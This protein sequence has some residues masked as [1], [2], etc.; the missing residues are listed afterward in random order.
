MAIRLKGL[1]SRIRPWRKQLG[2][3]G[4]GNRRGMNGGQ[5]WEQYIAALL[6]G[7]PVQ[8][9]LTHTAV[10]TRG[11][12]TPS[13]TRATTETGQRW[14]ESGYLDFTALAGEMV[15]KGA[16]REYNQWTTSSV[17]LASGAN[18]SLAL[19]AG[20][21]Q[22][23]MGA[24]TGTATFSGTGGATG[25]LGASASGR[26]SVAKT[27]TAGTF[28]VTASVADLADLQVC[29]ITGETD[30]TTIRPYV[31]VGVGDIEV[32]LTNPN[33]D[34]DTAWTKEAG[35]TISGGT[36]NFNG[37]SP[38]NIYTVNG[39]VGI[40]VEITYTISNYVSGVVRI[41]SGNAFGTV[42][43]ANG[44]YTEIIATTASTIFGLEAAA[45]SV[46]TQLSIE[47][48]SGR[49]L[50]HGS[51]VDGVKCY[52]TDRSGN[53]IATTGNYPLVGYVPWE[54]RT[55]SLLHARDLSNAAWVKV[56]CTGVKDAVGSDGVTNSASTL[57]A[58]GSNAT[59]LQTLVLA[60]AAR[61]Y[62]VKLKRK[63]GAGTV[64][65]C[66]D[67]VTFTDIT[68]QI[69]SSTYTTVKIENTSVLN[70]ICGIKLTTSGDAVYVDWNQ[71]EAGAF[72][73]PAIDT[74]TVAVARNANLLTYTGADVA[75]IKTLA[76]TFR[77]ESGVS[78]AGVV[79]QVDDGAGLAYGAA[80]LTSATNLRFEGRGT[81]GGGSIQ[82]Q[83]NAS[84]AYTEGTQSK[85]AYSMATNDI[86][87][88][89]DGT[90]Q[91]QDTS[92]T[93]PSFNQ[94]SVGYSGGSGAIQLNG[95]VN[96]I[97]GWTRNFSQSELGAVDRA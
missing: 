58:T 27:I 49:W 37:A 83:V 59:I 35:W 70:P 21:Y 41:R 6:S 18:K 24:G 25:T 2:Y 34:T 5:S 38:S 43:T 29:N 31:S 22:F 20:T 57:T 28:V 65:I 48:I 63:T 9:P 75:N 91:T 76:A 96:H 62:S 73:T 19:A 30:Q 86:K 32:P 44:T 82:W 53:L 40:S 68:A 93:I 36:A 26:V 39:R 87:M 52:D 16:R 97:Y 80:Y 90:A 11:S 1:M 85:V 8:I 77:R 69:N 67:G 33:F 46:A 17:S 88:D 14:D 51:C 47:N 72:S 95:C 94:L 7:A 45:G 92:A 84:N 4:I 89:K 81:G 56:N 42:R 15:F 71:D 3:L 50:D 66:R 78:S 79:A 55:N 60:A 13:F 74:T 54:A 61:S 23:S 12:L 64:S 10:P